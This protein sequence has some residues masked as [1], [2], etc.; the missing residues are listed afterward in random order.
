MIRMPRTLDLPDGSLSALPPVVEYECL[1]VD[2][3]ILVDGKL[4]ENAWKRVCWSEPFVKMD[5]GAA[6]QF[7]SRIALLWDDEFLYVAFRF[8]DEEI[9]GTHVEHHDHVYHRDSDAEI[10]IEGDGVY[11]E[12]GTNAINTIYEVLWTWLEPVVDRQAV[13]VIN[14]LFS[15]ENGLYFLPRRN[16][17]L[18][19][20]G[21]TDWQ[22]PGLKHAVAIDGS[23]N[24]PAIRDVGWTV[25]M[26]LPWAGLTVLGRAN[27]PPIAG[28]TWRIGA[29]RCQHFRQTSDAAQIQQIGEMPHP[30]QGYS[31]DWSWNCHGFVNMHIP[32]RWSVIRFV[33]RAV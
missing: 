14:R 1:R 25:E 19:R 33:D 20:F 31:V 3:D 9:W 27:C 10:F 11:Y 5:T 30:R 2:E 22:L 16:E 17:K 12:L 6:V 15:A 24:N 13:A 29:S 18:G 4:S 32:E 8:E 28:D 26:A 21:E 7:D 23:L